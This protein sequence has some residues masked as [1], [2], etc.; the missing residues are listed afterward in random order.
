MS[1]DPHLRM[2]QTRSQSNN[3]MEDPDAQ[4]DFWQ[5][6]PNESIDA[7]RIRM[8]GRIIT[9]LRDKVF[10]G[11]LKQLVKAAEGEDVSNPCYQSVSRIMSHYTTYPNRGALK[12]LG[13]KTE[14][15]TKLATAVFTALI[16]YYEKKDC[17]VKTSTFYQTVKTIGGF[18]RTYRSKVKK[19][20][21]S[22]NI[23]VRRMH[24]VPGSDDPVQMAFRLGAA[25]H[26][27]KT[28]DDLGVDITSQKRPRNYKG[29]NLLFVDQSSFNQMKV[30]DLDA[31][32]PLGVTTFVPNSTTIHTQSCSLMAMICNFG[33][34]I[35]YTVQ[36]SAKQAFTAVHVVEFLHSCI[37]NLPD[38][39]ENFVFLDNGRINIAV[40]KAAKGSDTLTVPVRK[41][42]DRWTD[43]TKERYRKEDEEKQRLFDEK[44]DLVR[45]IYE[46]IWAP[47]NTPESNLVEYYFRSLKRKVAK[48]LRSVN[49]TLS[50]SDWTEL[51]NG[52]VDKWMRKNHSKVDAMPHVYQFMKRLIDAGGSLEVE[53][54]M[55]LGYTSRDQMIASV[56][57]NV[58]DLLP[59]K[60]NQ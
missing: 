32:A 4:L 33:N 11:N 57:D 16:Q 50:G 45:A 1:S 24:N 26:F 51:V 34:I 49:G 47:T 20:L 58:R 56:L 19:I 48:R 40:F 7:F 23:R 12:H 17:Y 15:E 29:P 9:N 22:I 35:G 3:A 25:K 54:L 44:L 41:I 52:V 36:N 14:T 55:R 8:C 5:K 30:E 42:N 46:P 39:E 10:G 53:A 59:Q 18:D 2:V 6:A 13:Y 37:A 38:G 21:K 31:L 43:A 27:I 28:V 60:S